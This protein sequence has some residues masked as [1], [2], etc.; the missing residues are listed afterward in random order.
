[1]ATAVEER[2]L[3]A[4]EEG[5]LAVVRGRRWV[6]SEVVRSEL[7]ADATGDIPPHPQHLVSLVS[8]EDD[9]TG[10]ELVVV[11]ELEPGAESIERP[12][13]PR[14]HADR[15][16]EPLQLDAFLDAV[17]WG[18]VT[19]ADSRALQAPFRS[20]IAI[21]DYQLEPVVRALRMPRTNLLIAD[22]VGLGKTIEAGLVMQELLLRHRARTVLVVCPAALQIQWRDEMREKFGLEFRIVS[23]AL[24]AE[25]R[26]KRGVHANPF[27]HFPRLIVSMDW[28]KGELGMRLLRDT[29]PPAPEIPHRFDVLIIDEVHNVAPSGAGEHYATDTLRTRAVRE[30][31]PHCEHRLFLSATPHNGY[32]NSFA[33]LL[34]LLDPYRFA[35]GVELDAARVQ[36]VTVRRLKTEIFDPQGQPRFPEREIVALEVD[37]PESERA[38]HSGL[39]EYAALRSRRLHGYESGRVAA[40]FVTTLLKKRLFSSPAAFARTLAVHEET[41]RS[42]RTKRGAK[43]TTKVLRARFEDLQADVGDDQQLEEITDEALQ[44]AADAEDAQPSAG[45]FEILGR[46]RNWADAAARR[47]DAKAKRLIGWIEETVRPDG[48][49]NDERVI[50]YTEYRATQRYLHERLVGRGLDGERIALLDGTTPEDVRER[51]KARWQADPSLD[52]VRILLATDAASEG[53]SLQRHCHRLVHA[54]IPWNPNRLEQRNGRI[55]RHGQLATKVLVHHFVSSSWHDAQPGSLEADLQFLL[56]AARKVDRIREDLGSAGPVIERQVEEAML[57]RRSLLDEGAADR[58]AERGAPFRR[59]LGAERRMR[60]ELSRLRS[61]LEE[62]RNELDVHPKRVQQVVSVAL[63]LAGQPPLEPLGDGL[64]AVP[65]LTGSWAPATIGLEHPVTGEQRPITFDNDRAR[66]RDDVVLAHLGHR[67]VQ[68]SLGLLRAEVWQGDEGGLTRVTMRA[69][70]PAIIARP[71]AIAHGRLVVTGADG[72]RLHEEVVAAGLPLGEPTASARLNVSQTEAAIDAARQT[73][74]PRPMR[75]RLAAQLESVRS[76]LLAGLEARG[77]E[78]AQSLSRILADRATREADAIAEVLTEL[79]RTI[80]D[81]LTP[82]EEPQLTLWTPDERR[83]LERDTDVLRERLSRIPDDV[84][85]EVA[86]IRHRYSDPQPWL[87]PVMITLLV[88]EGAALS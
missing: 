67:L 66:E 3:S 22:D 49:W 1:M 10:E 59:L 5:Q 84:E 54:E 18:A 82:K 13:L 8:V 11:W 79:K 56:I 85:R 87:F 31:A 65:R 70:D 2:H 26:R 30:L 16:D 35:R 61:G 44:L 40:D 6:V 60:G 47:E 51:I 45:E 57:G 23:R 81:R 28:L 15:I 24:L 29:L 88:P 69:A 62:S 41:L 20:G 64:F 75:G 39:N 27:T 9:A 42:G 43:P 68:L 53:I 37:Y 17:R 32:S 21:E 86:A 58:A 50:V 74:V 14:V 12:D 71:T 80:E 83:Q 55:D 76:A 38:V 36:D 7:P 25:L 78:R 48:T 73:A 63:A 34:E 52:A 4:P 72:H 19:S 46:L 77:R 33:A